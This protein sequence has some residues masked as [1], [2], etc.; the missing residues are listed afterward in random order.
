MLTANDY[1]GVYAIIPTPCKEG[2]DRF[3]A[4]DTVN[5]D[6]TERLVNKLIDA[7]VEGL[8]ALGTTGECATLSTDDYNAFARCVLE[9]VNKRIP[10]FMGNSALGAHEVAA[11]TRLLRDAGADGVLLGLPQWQ[12]CTNEM[13]VK[14]Y[15]Q[16]AEA[17]PELTIMV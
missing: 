8:I 14:F 15:Q 13:A 11:R 9:T 4:V 3:D 12:I 7:G 16:F 1:R 10:T 17:F 2:G 6:E 5:L